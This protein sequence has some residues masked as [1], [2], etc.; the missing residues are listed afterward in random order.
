MKPSW[1]SRTATGS[2]FYDALI[3]ASALLLTL[4]PD[5]DDRLLMARFLAFDRQEPVRNGQ[6]L[7]AW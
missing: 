3:V 7:V 5:V 2:P 1:R 4:Y 6:I